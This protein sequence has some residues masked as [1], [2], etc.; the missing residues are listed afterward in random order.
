M[1]ATG[2]IVSDRELN[3][4]QQVFAASEPRFKE[5]QWCQL[6]LQLQFQ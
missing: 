4:F 1:S 2:L 6:S 5:E 3:L